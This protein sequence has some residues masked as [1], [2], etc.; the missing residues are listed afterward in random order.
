MKLICLASSSAGNAYY[1]E[2]DRKDQEPVKLLVE[3]GIKYKELVKK[4]AMNQKDISEVNAVLITHGHNDHSE[5]RLDLIKRGK[6]VFAN[7]HLA[8][9]SDTV[10][11]HGI[12]KYVAHNVLVTPFNVEHDAEDPLGFVIQTDKETILF[13][14]DLKYFKADLKK[15]KFDYI[16]IEANYDGQVIHFALENAKTSNN[17]PEIVRYERIVHSHMSISNCVKTLSTLDLSQCKA[18]FLMHLSD[19][20]ANELLFKKRVQDETKTSCFVC[21]KNGGLI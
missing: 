9:S 6:K 17:K 19:R 21:K 20:H 3:C 4:L 10:L 18:I 15:V 14:T 16:M 7:E 13:A 12:G 11:K 5:A 8:S 2:L 1:I